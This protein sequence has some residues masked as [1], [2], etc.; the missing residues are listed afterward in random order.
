M[1]ELRVGSAKLRTVAIRLGE[2][3]ADDLVRR[4][5]VERRLE[6]ARETLVQ[7]GP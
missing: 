6:P 1:P 2:V 3:E 7:L 5:T 4:L